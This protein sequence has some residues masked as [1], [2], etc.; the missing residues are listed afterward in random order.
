MMGYGRAGSDVEDEGCTVVLDV[1]GSQPGKH[2]QRWTTVET[3][4]R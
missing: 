2:G 4:N 1:D 3:G